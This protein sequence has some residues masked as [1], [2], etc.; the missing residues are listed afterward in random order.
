MSDAVAIAQVSDTV[1]AV[2]RELEGLLVRGLRAV[3]PQDLARLA[4]MRDELGRVGASHLAGDLDRLLTLTRADDR[5]ASAALLSALSTLRVFER[6][7]TLDT[8]AGLLEAVAAHPE[9]DPDPDDELDDGD[10]DDL[11]GDLDDGDAP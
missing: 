5:G 1:D 4:A 9:P 7:L 6:V 10:L 11:D 2:R 8:V 3:A